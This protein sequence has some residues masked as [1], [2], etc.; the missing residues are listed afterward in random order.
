MSDD[1][2]TDG[3]LPGATEMADAM[4]RIGEVMDGVREALARF[5]GELA[6]IAGPSLGRMAWMVKMHHHRHHQNERRIYAKAGRRERTG[7]AA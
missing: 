5:V 2:A 7:R 4:R 3:I 1:P 6:R